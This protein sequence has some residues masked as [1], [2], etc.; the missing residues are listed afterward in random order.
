MKTPKEF[1]YD[2][3]ITDDGQ[4]MVRIKATKEVCAV[5]QAVFRALRAEEKRLRREMEGVPTMQVDEDG[6]IIRAAMLSTD[7]VHVEDGEELDPW[8]LADPDDFVERLQL[9]EAVQELCAQLTPKQLE[10]FRE[11]LL[12]GIGLREYARRTSTNFKTAWET[13]DAIRKK[14]RKIFEG[15]PSKA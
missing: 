14:A 10:V 4:Y 6:E 9:K 8:W 13:A 5:E 2:L 15:T 1:A 12:K 7:F 3:W 11:C